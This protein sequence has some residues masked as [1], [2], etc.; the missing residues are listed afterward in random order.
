MGTH[1][2]G[3]TSDKQYVPVVRDY[4]GDRIVLCY[5]E[6]ARGFAPFSCFWMVKQFCAALPSSLFQVYRSFENVKARSLV[7]A[8]CV[9]SSHPPFAAAERTRLACDIFSLRDW[10]IKKE[11]SH[12]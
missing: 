5:E 8:L 1:V 12:G 4:Y 2:H 3:W 9:R 11:V 6:V 7:L 10:L